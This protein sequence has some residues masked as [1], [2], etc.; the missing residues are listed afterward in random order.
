MGLSCECSGNFDK[1][2]Y[3][4]WWEPGGLAVPPVGTK[5]CECCAPLP[6]E[7]C[8]SFDHMEV[9]EP[10]APWPLHPD[11]WPNV[12]SL[13]DVEFAEAEKAFDDFNDANGF[14]SETERFER[15]VAADYRCERCSDLASSIED[16]GYCLIGPGELIEDHGE[17]IHEHGYTPRLWRAGADGVYNP[18]P[19]RRRDKVASWVRK[20]R[21]NAWYFVRYGWKHWLRWKVYDRILHPYTAYR[22]GKFWREYHRREGAA[23]PSTQERN[24]WKP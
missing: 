2:E 14:D 22:T 9:W 5:C 3:D 10:Q 11:D 23:W 12:E 17:F 1:G 19:W 15:C 13:S 7:E 6:A 8:A 21:I 16:L 24:K 18:H 20:K 4:N